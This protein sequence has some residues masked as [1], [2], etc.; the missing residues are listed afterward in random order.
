MLKDNKIMFKQFFLDFKNNRNACD[1]IYKKP[2]NEIIRNHQPIKPNAQVH[3]VRQV[4]PQNK[5]LV[6]SNLNVVSSEIWTL[7]HDITLIKQ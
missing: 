1:K 7:Y 6:K 5:N 2:L 3:N 4:Q